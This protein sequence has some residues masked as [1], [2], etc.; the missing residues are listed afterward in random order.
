MSDTQTDLDNAIAAVLTVVTTLGTDLN[1]TITALQAKI[2]SLQGPPPPPTIDF[3]PEVTS[4]Q[5]I[6]A[7][8]TTLDSTAVA[9]NPNTPPAAS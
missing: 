8:L 5:N 7:T 3:T 6:A 4:L 9:A 2:A 1:A